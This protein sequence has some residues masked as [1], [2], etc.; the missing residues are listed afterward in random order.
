MLDRRHA[1]VQVDERRGEHGDETDRV[2][3]HDDTRAQ[4]QRRTHERRQPGPRHQHQQRPGELDHVARPPEQQ[5]VVG[6]RVELARHVGRGPHQGHQRDGARNRRRLQAEAQRVGAVELQ[7][8]AR[9]RDERAQR[10]QQEPHTEH[11][12]PIQ[13][14]VVVEHRHVVRHHRRRRPG[15]RRH[16]HEQR[17]EP[18]DPQREPA[19]PERAWR[20]V[21]RPEH[22]RHRHEPDQHREI[23]VHDERD[24]EEI[25]RRDQAGEERRAREHQQD[26]EHAGADQ[27]RDS[28]QQPS[29]GDRTLLGSGNGDVE[30]IVAGARRR[31]RDLAGQARGRCLAHRITTP[32]WSG[33]KSISTTCPGTTVI[34]RSPSWLKPLMRT[35]S[36][37]CTRSW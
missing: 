7:A 26:R 2:D 22:A 8:H 29:G 33:M 30:A 19:E 6:A 1:P 3:E 9:R 25:A 34:R 37:N 17:A 14:R 11:D 31:A 24:P 20:R 12:Q 10:E 15:E 27:R 21:D 23:D 28:E 5:L 35:L 36:L 4:R 32:P 16:G 13:E 18:G